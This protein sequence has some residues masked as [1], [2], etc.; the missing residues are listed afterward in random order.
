MVPRAT[1]PAPA[2]AAPVLLNLRCAVAHNAPHRRR[3]VRAAAGKLPSTGYFSDA[4]PNG[5]LPYH[6]CSML[7]TCA[8]TPTPC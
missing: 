2:Q 3:G 1:M 4:D 8:G 7:S 6:L 5:A